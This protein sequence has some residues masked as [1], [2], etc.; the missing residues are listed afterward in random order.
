MQDHFKN[1]NEKL[2]K[3]FNSVENWQQAINRELEDYT[4]ILNE[5]IKEIELQNNVWK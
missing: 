3:K 1:L 2:E 4:K 5:K